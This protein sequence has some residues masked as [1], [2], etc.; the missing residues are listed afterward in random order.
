[1]LGAA[2]KKTAIAELNKTN[3]KYNKAFESSVQRMTVLQES[4]LSAVRLLKGIE[5]YIS[6]LAN[7]PKEYDTTIGRV[8]KQTQMFEDAVMN[9][10]IESRKVDKTGSAVA[11][12]GAFVGTSIA[13]LGPSAAMAVAMTFGTASTGT[14]IATLSGAA[15]TKAAL[16][17]L[18]GGALTAGGAGVTGGQAFLALA[19]PIGWAIGGAALAGGG[20][21]LNYKN[22]AIAEKAENSIRAVNKEIERITKIDLQVKELCT[23]TSKLTTITAGLFSKFKF[24]GIRDYNAFDDNQVNDLMKLMNL[25]ETLSKQIG[26]VLGGE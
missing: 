8:K 23:V 17:W 5:K 24:S 1:M 12:V 25:A 6:D 20:I 4:R 19:G 9:L 22:K 7:R 15:A 13:A 26:I 3:E 16:A 18:G 14:A 11:G 21:Y 10:E 2:Y